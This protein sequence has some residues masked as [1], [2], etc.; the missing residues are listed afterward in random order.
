MQEEQFRNHSKK[1]HFINFW[2]KGLGKELLDWSG[3]KPSLSRLDEL[4]AYYYKV[5]ELADEVV[6]ETYLKYPYPEATKIIE[7]HKDNNSDLSKE[8]KLE[9]LSRLLGELEHTPLWLDPSLAL[10]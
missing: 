9:S 10:E 2:Q 8:E 7:K 5:D 1:P 3:A 6:K 4:S